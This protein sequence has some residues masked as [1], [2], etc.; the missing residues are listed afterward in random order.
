[1]CP[2]P[3]PAPYLSLPARTASHVGSSPPAQD[4]LPPSLALTG[5]PSQPPGRTGFLAGENWI[6]PLG[7]VE[8]AVLCSDVRGRERGTRGQ[9]QGG[10]AGQRTQQNW[11][12]TAQN[13]ALC[14]VGYSNISALFTFVLRCYS[15]GGVVQSTNRANSAVVVRKNLA[16]RIP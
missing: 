13:G 11:T 14:T 16:Y 4:L 6:C 15:G 10:H 5:T 3:A 8:R 7:R 9:G 12:F 1:M 2:V